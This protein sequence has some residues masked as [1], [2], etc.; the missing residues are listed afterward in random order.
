MRSLFSLSL[1]LFPHR[2]GPVGS[3][4]CVY[5]FHSDAD[6][7]GNVFKGNYKKTEG[8]S[9]VVVENFVDFSVSAG[10]KDMS[11]SGK[12]L[13]GLLV[14]VFSVIMIKL[15]TTLNFS[16]CEAN[17]RTVDEARDIQ[18]MESPV[19]QSNGPSPLLE[20]SGYTF[21]KIVVDQVVDADGSRHE[22]MFVTAH[23]NGKLYI[24][25]I[26]KLAHSLL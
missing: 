9:L 23:K 4:V 3:A 19:A 13:K 10:C 17:S 15:M 22:V 8:G 14:K 16:Q 1:S 18:L 11:N 12:L 2:N 5:K 26:C 25:S 6:D 24:I 7:L 20:L 21:R